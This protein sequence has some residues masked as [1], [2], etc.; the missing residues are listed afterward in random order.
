MLTPVAGVRGRVAA[1]SG[2]GRLS[3]DAKERSN[4][5]L[6]T[7]DAGEAV[8]SLKAEDGDPLPIIR[9]LSLVASLLGLG[10]VD[11]VRLAGRQGLGAGA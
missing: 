10:L 6:V 8:R 4:T 7:S 1:L 5:T 11:R 9:S 2:S 3:G